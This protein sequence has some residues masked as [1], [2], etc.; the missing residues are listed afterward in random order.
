[1]SDFDII[2]FDLFKTKQ[3]KRLSEKEV[4]SDKERSDHYEEYKVELK[5]D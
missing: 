3:S 2:K 5:E 1:L 4:K